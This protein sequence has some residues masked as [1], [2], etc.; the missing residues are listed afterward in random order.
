MT[1][2]ASLE[3]APAAH[4]PTSLAHRR[5]YLALAAVAVCYSVVQL[6]FTAHIGLGWDESVY[7]SQV[8]HGVPPSDFSA[9]RARGVP[10][11]LAPVAIF[12]SSV[13]AL[14]I[15]LSLLSGAGL[16]LAYLPWLR[17]R[18]SPLVPLAALLFSGTWLALFYG[19]EAMPNLYVAFGAV[20]GAALF[21]LALAHR[22]WALLGLVAAFAL[23][24][25]VRPTDAVWLAAP[26][27]AAAVLV[28][29]WRRR[30]AP[31]AVCAGLAVGWGAWI[32][33]AVM[34]YGGPVARLRA[35][36][37]MNDTGWHFTLTEHLR[38]LDGPLLCRYGADCGPY[39]LAQVA[40]FAAVPV[41][42][43]LG[44]W[45][46]RRDALRGPLIL[47]LLSGACLLGGYVFTVGY[48]APRFLLPAYALLAL[49]VAA[50]L[51]WPFTFSGV[52][53]ALGALAAAVAVGGFL[54]VQA[55]TLGHQVAASAPSRA[56]NP[57]VKARLTAIGLHP[58]C[59]LYGHH[60][61]EVGYLAGCASRGVVSHYGGAHPP[62]VISA[63]LRQN[64]AVAVI[65]ASKR[66]PAPYLSTWTKVPLHLSTGKTWY[67]YRPPGTPK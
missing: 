20:A 9:P 34:H 11:L 67:A 33:E 49:P 59:L 66:L 53:R 43:V 4:S 35:A 36:G 14:R 50:A 61:V 6:A 22:R 15:Y 25:L 12:T 58:P 60:G 45:V 65:T 19:N 27:L 3:L 31:V 41:L 13:T 56:E 17:L 8:A 44:V 28:P 52:P 37:T 24:S 63:A 39:P 62:K 30:P 16:F 1:D 10:L 7:A 51:L 5:W 26:L 38:A 32:V 46:Y 55:V 42:A 40:W 18:D 64:V 57:L 2:L 54:V 23:I 29:A 47:A 48:A 21:P